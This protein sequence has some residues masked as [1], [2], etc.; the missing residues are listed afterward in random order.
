MKIR[1][2]L[3]MVILLLS[4]LQAQAYADMIIEEPIPMRDMP[5]TYIK[6]DTIFEAAIDENNIEHAEYHIH[7]ENENNYSIET[8]LE[9]HF[10]FIPENIDVYRDGKKADII[11]ES[12]SY[13]GSRYRL[14]FIIPDSGN[15]SVDISYTILKTPLT[16]D[17]GIWNLRYQYSSPV[18]LQ[19]ISGYDRY[20]NYDRRYTGN[21][22]FGYE[23]HN[24]ICN[25]CIYKDNTVRIEDETYFHVN[26]DKKRIPVRSGI[27]YIAMILAIAYYVAGKRKA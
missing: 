22:T 7:I 14:K 16:W 3:I 1:Q 2:T 8:Y 19:F 12:E 11:T 23:P 27:I 20:L 6:A 21:I 10:Q 24:V 17:I 13:T 25:N 9:I 4:A 18:N 15:S 5:G 26:W